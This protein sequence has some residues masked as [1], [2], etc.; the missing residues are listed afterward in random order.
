MVPPLW[1]G[2]GSLSGGEP[3]RLAASPAPPPRANQQSPTRTANIHSLVVTFNRI[4]PNPP[5]NRCFQGGNFSVTKIQKKLQGLQRANNSQNVKR[6]EVLKQTLKTKPQ[7][8]DKSKK[9]EKRTAELFRQQRAVENFRLN[10]GNAT[11]NDD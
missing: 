7:L 2:L 9:F 6:D 3:V 8:H 4:Y 11:E 5:R 10:S 1:K